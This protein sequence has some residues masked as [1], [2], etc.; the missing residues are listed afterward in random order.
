MSGVVYLHRFHS[1]PVA[2]SSV[3]PD[4][5]DGG[6]TL[7]H[8]LSPEC[9]CSHLLRDHFI[10][11]GPSSHKEKIYII[12]TSDE[13]LNRK[14]SQPLEKAGFKTEL[15]SEDKVSGVPLLVIQNT[16]GESL[17]TGG[18]TDG[19]IRPDS[20]ILDIQIA[21][22]LK[23]RKNTTAYNAFGCAVSSKLKK[24]IDPLGVKSL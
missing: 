11:R 13:S 19:P 4:R 8:F 20:I 18:Y 7:T 24:Y 16:K 12:K 6:L 15:I 17:Y 23:N 22:D 14:I 10:S 2:K 5:L 1:I 3:R 21:N 9:K